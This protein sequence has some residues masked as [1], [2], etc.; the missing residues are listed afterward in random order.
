MDFYC[1][2]RC[3]TCKKAKKF[4][5]EHAVHYEEKNL[6]EESLE[7]EEWVQILSQTDRTL[8]SF[9]NTSGN[10][11]RENNLKE[12]L[13]D[14]TTEEAAE[15]LSSNGMVVK[16]PFAI[17]GSTCTSGFKEEEYKQVWLNKGETV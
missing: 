17:S 16:R 5:D 6:L 13:P 11:Y 8:K 9:F 4:L 3:S 14:M 7:K 12:K 10:V 1:H 15:W 2:P